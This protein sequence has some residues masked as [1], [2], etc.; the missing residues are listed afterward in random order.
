[1]LVKI[2][3]KSPSQRDIGKV[4]DTLTTGGVMIYPTDSLYAYGCSIKSA[5]GIEQL[6]RLSGKD[7]NSL[8]LICRDI[9]QVAEYCR[10]DNAQ[11][12]V[13]KRNLPGAFTFIL[14]ASNRLPDKVLMKRST[15]GIRIPDNE[16]VMAILESI[17]SPLISS[18]LKSDDDIEYTTDAELIHERWG[19]VVDIVVDGGQGSTTP[20]TVVDMS[21][22]E[23]EIIRE[24]EGELI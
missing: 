24:G 16:I 22:G 7:N 10:I 13:L 21:E 15:I 4:R 19:D 17:E 11:F 9:S 14:K 20:S 1:M 18:S 8:T 5:K 3:S 12:K 6:K 2:Y 23:V